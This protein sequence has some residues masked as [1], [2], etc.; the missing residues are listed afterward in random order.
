MICA[1]NALN[2]GTRR[3]MAVAM[4]LQ[5]FTH[6]QEIGDNSRDAL[7]LQVSFARIRRRGLLAPAAS[8]LY[9]T[10][11]PS[12]ATERRVARSFRA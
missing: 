3:N 6:I 5:R 1:V 2:R 12:Y 8:M 10:I 11:P 9:S 7:G 4:V